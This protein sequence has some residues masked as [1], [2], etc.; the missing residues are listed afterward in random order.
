MFLQNKTAV[1]KV[2]TGPYLIHIQMECL[3]YVPV[4]S[5]TAHPPGQTKAQ[6]FIERWYYWTYKSNTR[7]ERWDPQQPMTTKEASFCPFNGM[8]FLYVFLER[9]SKAQNFNQ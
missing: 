7:K 2:K 9:A 5:K 3:Q 4:N 6:H 1:G 8:E